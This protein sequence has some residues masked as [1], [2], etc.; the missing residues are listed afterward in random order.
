M[1][2]QSEIKVLNVAEKPSVARAL[3]TVFGHMPTITGH[4]GGGGGPVRDRGMHRDVHQVFTH[5]NVHFPSVFAQ[6]DG[7]II[8][9]PSTYWWLVGWLDV[10][11]TS[12]VHPSKMQLIHILYIYICFSFLSRS[13]TT[14]HDHNIGTG[15][16]S[17]T[18]FSSRI[19]LE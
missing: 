11:C 17:H 8:Q 12:A 18:R 19:R 4:G 1:V 5:E 9:G 2:Q 10:L 3:A 13:D 15:T 7:R 6:G 16:F 14:Y